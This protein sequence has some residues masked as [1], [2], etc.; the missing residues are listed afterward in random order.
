MISRAPVVAGMFGSLVH[1]DFLISTGK[2]ITFPRCSG[3]IH[4]TFL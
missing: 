3:G 1:A 2:S 4:F